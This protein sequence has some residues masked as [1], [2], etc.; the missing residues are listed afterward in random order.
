MVRGHVTTRSCGFNCVETNV[1]KN[2]LNAKSKYIWKTRQ[3]NTSQTQ[4]QNEEHLNATLIFKTVLKLTI[5]KRIWLLCSGVL[6]GVFIYN[7]INQFHRENA[8]GIV[9]TLYKSWFLLSHMFLWNHASPNSDITSLGA[10][11]GLTLKINKS[12]SQRQ[13]FR[14]KC[15]VSLMGLKFG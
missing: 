1:E 14:S 5:N 6:F 4:Y 15:V 9:T 13:S 2:N 8:S 12:I 11:A 3:A 7:P 10:R